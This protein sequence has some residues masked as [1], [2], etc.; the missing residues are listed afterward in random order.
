MS[1]YRTIEKYIPQLESLMC[2]DRKIAHYLLINGYI[3]RDMYEN[4]T[5]PDSKLSSAEKGGVLVSAVL[6]KVELNSKHYKTF[7]DRLREDICYQDIVTLLDEEYTRQA[8]PEDVSSP[9][10]AHEGKEL[11]QRHVGLV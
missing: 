7:V 10:T 11:G 6:K 8:V 2:H 5:G 1:E 9:N 3:F 4:V